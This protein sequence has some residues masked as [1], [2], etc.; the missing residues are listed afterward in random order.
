MLATIVCVGLAG[1]LAL[2]LAGTAFA[3]SYE[4][5][6]LDGLFAELRDA[7][8]ARTAGAVTQQIWK[9]WLFLAD[10][11]QRLLVE[12]GMMQMRQGEQSAAAATF[13]QLIEKAP[14]LP[15]PWHKR[16]S[17]HQLLG[18][19]PL[20]IAD[21]CAALKREPRHFGA[22]ANLGA[23][24]LQVDEPVRALAAFE[25]ALRYNPRMPGMQGEIDKLRSTLGAVVAGPPLGCDQRVSSR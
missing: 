18:E 10:P 16:G 17:A 11:Q 13:T 23:V 15:E 4:P 5:A 3:Q 1:L 21:F 12:L 25:R 14:D 20:A 19:L 7:P 22:Y 6:K 2:H 8:D 24:W 9:Q